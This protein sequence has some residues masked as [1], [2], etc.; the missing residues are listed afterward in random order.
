MLKKS[1]TVPSTK[2]T[3]G[4]SL[5]AWLNQFRKS[6]EFPDRESFLTLLYTVPSQQSQTH[7]KNKYKWHW[8]NICRRFANHKTGDYRKT[9]VQVDKFNSYIVIATDTEIF[10]IGIDCSDT[11]DKISL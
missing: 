9:I 11:D 6:K 4:K 10:D 5:Y 2:T 1:K 8:C 7:H 3:V